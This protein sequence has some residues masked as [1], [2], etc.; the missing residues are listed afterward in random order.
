MTV[1]VA[2]VDGGTG[3]FGRLVMSNPPAVSGKAPLGKDVFRPF[4]ANVV[5][6]MQSEDGP[7]SGRV[8]MLNSP[9]DVDTVIRFYRE[10]MPVKGWDFEREFKQG[11][12]KM[13]VFRKGPSEYN[14]LVLPTAQ[15]FSQ[16]LIN[17]VE[18]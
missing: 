1:Q 5:S 2:N 17:S 3:S 14:V 7:K 6:D 8:T 4:N 11:G 13:I 9:D 10:N 16:I 12:G 18:I 15:G